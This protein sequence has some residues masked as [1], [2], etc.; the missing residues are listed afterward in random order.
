[1]KIRTLFAVA[2][3]SLALC[4]PVMARDAIEIVVRNTFQNAVFPPAATSE[5]KSSRQSPRNDPQFSGGFAQF[6]SEGFGGHSFGVTPG[7]TLDF[8]QSKD[9]HLKFS[10]PLTQIDF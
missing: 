2:C 8:G 5:Q 7:F 9:Q 4:S 1:M 6:S 3:L 10:F